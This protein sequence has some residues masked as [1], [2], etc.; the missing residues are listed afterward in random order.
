MN[1]APP[2]AASPDWCR[3]RGGR[4]GCAVGWPGGS[5]GGR[6]RRR[7]W[8]LGRRRGSASI[9]TRVS[10]EGLA[11]LRRDFRAIGAGLNRELNAELREAAAIASRDAASLAPRRTGRL[12]ASYK[13]FARGNAIG[14]RSRLP[15][16]AVHE[17]GGTIRP[18]GVPIDIRRS[19]PVSQAV[20]RNADRIVEELGD[21]IEGLARRHGFR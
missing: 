17:W 21:R 16:A 15:Y 13:P 12:A 1:G 20:E 19:A 6:W 9:D 18:R 10:I 7:R 2:D 8:R 4:A 3:V 14:V 11:D 5:P